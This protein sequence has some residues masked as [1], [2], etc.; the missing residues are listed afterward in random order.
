MLWTLSHSLSLWVYF[1]FS[2]LFLLLSLLSISFPLSR[3]LNLQ[4]NT[5]KNRHFFSFC[6]TKKKTISMRNVNRTHPADSR[7]LINV[8]IIEWN[9]FFFSFHQT[10]ERKKNVF[11][12][13]AK[14]VACVS[15]V[16][17]IPLT[18][19][20]K[21]ELHEK[22]IV[23]IKCEWKKKYIYVRVHLYRHVYISVL[24]TNCEI[25]SDEKC[26]SLSLND[27]TE[28]EEKDRQ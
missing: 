10:T 18:K 3:S 16:A 14:Y 22:C 8:Y 11:F 24:W 23:R 2:T 28:I 7:F 25:T 5:Q 27:S 17:N 13:I 9:S 26:R 21:C 19:I 6:H 1:C 12:A 15:S 4:Q 20:M